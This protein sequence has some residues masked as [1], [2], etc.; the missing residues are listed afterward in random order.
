MR[1]EHPGAL[2]ERHR[3]E[4]RAADAAAVLQHALEVEALAGRLRDLLA[5]HR[6]EQLGRPAG[7]GD[8]LPLRV[9]LQSHA[10]L[11]VGRGRLPGLVP[12][13]V[14]RLLRG[15]I[16]RDLAERLGRHERAPEP[17]RQPLVEAG[18]LGLPRGASR[19]RPASRSSQ[20]FPRR[21]CVAGSAISAG[22][23]H[24]APTIDSAPTT[25]RPSPRRSS[26]PARS[27]RSGPRGSTAPWPMCALA[28]STT[29]TPGNM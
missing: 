3:P 4:L 22:T 19:P 6:V 7:P 8:P 9:A 1:L 5:R 20:G 12:C 14:R 25:A 28:S 27:G 2:V 23:K 17:L 11:S 15:A 29:V 13:L 18:A 21:P 26:R 24:S 10:L 16:G